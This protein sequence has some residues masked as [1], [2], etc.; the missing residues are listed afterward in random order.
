MKAKVIITSAIAAVAIVG[1]GA[2]T[3]LASTGG[4]HNT[5]HAPDTSLVQAGDA[6]PD[7]S[8]VEKGEA[9]E[10]TDTPVVVGDEGTTGSPTTDRSG[11]HT[12]APTGG[13]TKSAPKSTQSEL[14][15]VTGTGVLVTDG[16]VNLTEAK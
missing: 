11:A 6:K 14:N 9:K 15:K 8:K 16:I 3:A 10:L 5:P 4:P 7:F 12:K 1:G 13:P 2:A